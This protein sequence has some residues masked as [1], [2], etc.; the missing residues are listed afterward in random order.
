MVSSGDEI[1][2][3]QNLCYEQDLSGG[4]SRD[5]PLATEPML[6]DAQTST[7]AGVRSVADSEAPKAIEERY[8]TTQAE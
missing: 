6:G 5:M 8:C 3:H 2:V 4:T 7:S 1:V